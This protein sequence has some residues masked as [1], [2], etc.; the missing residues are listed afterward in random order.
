MVSPP[1]LL[2]V[3]VLLLFQGTPCCLPVTDSIFPDLSNVLFY[4]VVGRTLREEQDA[5]N[6]FIRALPRCHGRRIL[7]GCRLRIALE[8]GGEALPIERQDCVKP[9]LVFQKLGFIFAVKTWAK[10]QY[11]LDAVGIMLHHDAVPVVQYQ[12]PT[13]ELPSL[14][15]ACPP[16]LQAAM[17]CV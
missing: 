5:K 16:F 13:V 6:V 4:N 11:C 2:R 1:S 9:V 8:N 10:L 15:E 17:H 14:L 7:C 12:T 3:A